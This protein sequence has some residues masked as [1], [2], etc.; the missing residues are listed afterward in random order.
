MVEE[1]GSTMVK[2]IILRESWLDTRCTAGSYVHV[3]GSFDMH[4]LCIVDDSQNILILHPDHLISALVVADSYS[5]MRK[6][7]LEDRIKAASESSPPMLY[8]TIIHEIFQNALQANR[9]D[10]EWLEEDIQKLVRRH[11]EDLYKTQL[12]EAQAIDHLTSKLPAIKEWASTFVKQRPDLRTLVE[13]PHGKQ[14]KLSVN[15]LLDVEEHIWSPMFGLKGNID[16]TVQVAVEDEDGPRTLTV[17][18]ELKTGK[19][20][21]ASHRAQTALYTLMLSDRYGESL[22]HLQLNSKD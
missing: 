12:S 18:F 16:A 9:W 21:S 13:D 17:P 8:G 10:D 6:A 11:I 2:S 4:G 20:E 19:R 1:E 15:K 7:V 5:C 14:V 22:K 3:I